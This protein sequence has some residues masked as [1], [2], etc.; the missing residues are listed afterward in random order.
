MIS[1]A[2]V[3]DRNG[4]LLPHA[5]HGLP[6]ERFKLL[7]A[8]L[9]ARNTEAADATANSRANE[10]SRVGMRMT[11]DV[12][13]GV[14]TRFAPIH[15][16]W[17]YCDPSVSTRPGVTFC[18]VQGPRRGTYRQQRPRP[19]V[20]LLDRALSRSWRIPVDPP[21]IIPTSRHAHRANQRGG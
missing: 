19:L 5:L 14:R 11:L 15:P 16:H 18:R 9:E 2:R 13:L 10:A 7:R 6:R 21:R 8:R 12:T 3:I 4:Q 20:S 1:A 17:P